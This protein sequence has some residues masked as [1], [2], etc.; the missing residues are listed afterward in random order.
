MRAAG[1]GDRC[2]PS[3]VC[4]RRDVQSSLPDNPAF[5][6]SKTRT[7][8]RLNNGRLSH[9]VVL[10]TANE[11][12]GLLSTRIVWIDGPQLPR[13]MMRFDIERRVDGTVGSR[14]SMSN[15]LN[16]H[17]AL[18]VVG[19]LHRTRAT[20]SICFPR[21]FVLC[22]SLRASRRRSWRIA[23]HWIEPTSVPLNDGCGT[24]RSRTFSVR[25]W[26]FRWISA[27]CWIR[28]CRMT[29]DLGIKWRT[30]FFLSSAPVAVLNDE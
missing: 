18:R 24:C 9:V 23:R 19:R 27:S 6:F 11:T 28:A 4:H 26:R 30:G 14:S 16:D 5:V 8:R 3:R 2:R 20:C 13:C 29:L 25:Q 22:L 1:Q 15:S 21:T 12:A 10:V 17:K 7:G